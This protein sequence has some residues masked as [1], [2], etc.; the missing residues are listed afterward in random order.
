MEN[1]GF[2]FTKRK[3]GKKKRFQGP[4]DRRGRILPICSAPPED[5]ASHFSLGLRPL[6]KLGLCADPQH[7]R[8]A[9]PKVQATGLDHN[10]PY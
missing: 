5:P 7:P 8:C 6:V 1:E 10:P 9:R 2:Y 3:Q 4:K